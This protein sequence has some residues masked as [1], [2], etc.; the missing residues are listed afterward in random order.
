MGTDDVG[1]DIFARFNKGAQLSLAVGLVAALSG[2]L[3]GGLLGIIGGTLG[4][5][6]DL[7]VMRVM[8]ALLA[9]PPLILIMAVTLGLG[10]GVRSATIGIVITTV[11]W[12]ARLVR[13]DAL[14]IRGRQFIEATR[15]LGATRQRLVFR[16]VIPHAMPTLLVQGAHAFGYAILSLAAL[17]FIGLG[18]QPPTPEWGVM[19]TEGLAYAITGQW[20]IGVF[21]GIGVLLAVTAAN[22]YADRIRELLDP[23]NTKGGGRTR[24]RA[25]HSPGL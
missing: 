11:P 10:V 15:A 21:P 2:A 19:V 17:G 9:F 7:S 8:D 18:A 25:T 1:R 22:I 12:Y 14:S 23:R 3:I 4:G 6:F 13:S 20:W 16:H 24:W 5:L